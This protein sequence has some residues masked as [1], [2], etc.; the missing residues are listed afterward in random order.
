MDAAV[1]AAIVGVVDTAPEASGWEARAAGND[2]VGCRAGS[3]DRGCRAGSLDRGCRAGSLDPAKDC[4][5][6][7][8]GNDGSIC[9]ATGST[10]RLTSAQ[11]HTRW[12]AAAEA[13]RMKSTCSSAARLT[14]PVAFTHNQNTGTAVESA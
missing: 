6:T 4:T 13:R 12:R 10:S 11:I 1:G 2:S 7:A 14:T 5:R 3:L 8:N 9:D